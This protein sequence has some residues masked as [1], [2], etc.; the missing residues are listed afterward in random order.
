M[1][2]PFMR[3]RMLKLSNSPKT[4]QAINVLSLE[5]KTFG[6]TLMGT[7]G[8]R[9]REAHCQS[10]Q[11][12]KPELRLNHLTLRSFDSSQRGVHILGMRGKWGQPLFEMGK[13][14]K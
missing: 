8:I 10:G 9:R 13:N 1:G 6:S 12:I 3:V 4:Y 5:K 7:C 11:A 2:V 14:I